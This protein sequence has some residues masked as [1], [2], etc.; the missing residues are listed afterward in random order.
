MA[1]PLSIASSIAGLI[2]L[3]GSLIQLSSSYAS[4]N[5][6]DL[7][8]RLRLL[9]QVLQ[10]LE[11]FLRSEDTDKCFLDKES[12]LFRAIN[13]CQ[14]KLENVFDKLERTSKKRALSSLSAGI[15]SLKRPF[16]EESYKELIANL[17]GYI[18]TFGFS[19][20]IDGWYI[21]FLI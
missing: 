13:S 10:K 15:K 14:E 16:V 9:D 5:T 12:V 4:N 8:D 21:Y 6:D 19:L 11:A 18:Q 1:D 20:S 3:V 17:D 2:T 7:L